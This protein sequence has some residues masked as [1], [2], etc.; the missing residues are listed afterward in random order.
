MNYGKF[1]HLGYIVKNILS[2][3]VLN[4]KFFHYFCLGLHYN[5][6]ENSLTKYSKNVKIKRQGIKKIDQFYQLV[7]SFFSNFPFNSTLLWNT[8]ELIKSRFIWR[9]SFAIFA[10]DN[11]E[12]YWNLQQMSPALHG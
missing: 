5:W 9:T 2:C 10:I 6:Q 1:W 12:G 4:F 3:Y 7:F 8:G 11:I